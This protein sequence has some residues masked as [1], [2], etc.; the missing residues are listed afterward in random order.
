M[1]EAAA[2][3]SESTIL[4]HVEAINIQHLGHDSRASYFDKKNVV[5]TDSIKG[6]EEGKTSLDFMGLNHTL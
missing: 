2:R 5:E 6:V 3:L 4:P 1:G